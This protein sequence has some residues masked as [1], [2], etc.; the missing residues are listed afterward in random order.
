LRGGTVILKAVKAGGWGERSYVKIKSNT[1][2]LSKRGKRVKN[3]HLN[4]IIIYKN[5][6]NLGKRRK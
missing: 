4:I 5:K 2:K 6:T 3:E 1:M